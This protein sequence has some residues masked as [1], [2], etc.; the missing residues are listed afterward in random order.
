MADTGSTLD[1]LDP[2]Q[3]LLQRGGPVVLVLLL[4]ALLAT[5]I[6][7]TKT[8]Q[9]HRLGIGHS[10]ELYASLREWRKGYWQQAIDSLKAVP[11]H[12]VGRDGRQRRDRC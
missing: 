4:M 2:L 9:F 12:P 7:I 3:Q 10:T 8:L 1:F 5:V 6:L 11:D